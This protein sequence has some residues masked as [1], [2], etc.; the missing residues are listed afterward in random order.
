VFLG[1]FVF[2]ESSLLLKWGFNFWDYF[3]FDFVLDLDFEFELEFIMDF[4]GLL[5]CFWS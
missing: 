1:Y 2:W 4:T 5:F 3:V